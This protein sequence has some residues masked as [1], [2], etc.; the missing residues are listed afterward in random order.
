MGLA[1]KKVLKDYAKS[2]KLCACGCGE[3]VNG[4]IPYAKTPD[5]GPLLSRTCY[6]NYEKWNKVVYA[7]PVVK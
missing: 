4:S 6:E 3:A 5:G 7:A 2:V 1:D